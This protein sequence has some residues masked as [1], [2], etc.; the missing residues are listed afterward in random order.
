[1]W[2]KMLTSCRSKASTFAKSPWFLWYFKTSTFVWT[3]TNHF[4]FSNHHREPVCF[5]IDRTQMWKEVSRLH[6]SSKFDRKKSFQK[7]SPVLSTLKWIWKTT[8]GT[9]CQFKW[10]SGMRQTKM[11]VWQQIS[12]GITEKRLSCLKVWMVPPAR[13][14]CFFVLDSFLTMIDRKDKNTQGRGVKVSKAN[15]YFINHLVKASTSIV[16][17]LN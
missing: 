7:Y 17:T 1:M 10:N 9:D 2:Y 8:K 5:P 15:S 12:L 6:F 4:T 11:L 14:I 16:I 13:L 3:N